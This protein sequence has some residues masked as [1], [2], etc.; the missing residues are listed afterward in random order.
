[1]RFHQKSKKLGTGLLSVSL[2]FIQVSFELQKFKILSVRMKMM[3]VALMEI[4]FE[5]FTKLDIRIGKVE[6]AEKI[7][8]SRNLL[9]LIVDFGFEKRQCVAGL[10]SF[11]E[12][13]TLVD[14]KFAFVINMQRRK[15]LG[16]ESQCM[17][18]AA[19]D[20][21]GNVSLV[22]VDKDIMLGSKVG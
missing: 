11:Y 5:D 6:S 8:E 3:L 15:L 18:L 22:T 1:M 16:I 4:T 17:I 13:E 2:N 14:K 12:P 19:E 9:K 10:Q 7:P 21:T 20:D